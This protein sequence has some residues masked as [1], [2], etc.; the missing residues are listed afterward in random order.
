M[1]GNILGEGFV[2]DG[3]S[4]G[5]SPRLVVPVAETKATFLDMGKRRD[6]KP[7][8]IQ[9]A[10]RN[11]G[12]LNIAA[13]VKFLNDGA[14]NANPL[15]DPAIEDQLKWIQAVFRQQVCFSVPNN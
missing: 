10:I 12:P 4:L 8:T 14:V 11:R 7:N 6:G 3:V 2:F 13:L 9:V 15:G 1:L 5:W